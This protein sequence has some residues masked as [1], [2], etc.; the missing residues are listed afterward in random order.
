MKQLYK[1]SNEK[2]IS[3]VCAGIAEYFQ[4]EYWIVR[5]LVV[6]LLLIKPSLVIIYLIMAGTLPY[7]YQLKDTPM[8]HRSQD[9]YWT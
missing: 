3:G 6:A 5:L 7:D 8:S 1:S 4:I 9:E 2:V